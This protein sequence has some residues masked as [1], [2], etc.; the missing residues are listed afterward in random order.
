M[1]R[2]GKD[3]DMKRGCPLRE[4]PKYMMSLW[5]HFES[6]PKFST[7]SKINF[8]KFGMPLWFP[9]NTH[10][11]KGT[12]SKNRQS[13]KLTPTRVPTQKRHPQVAS[14]CI[15]LPRFFFSSDRPAA[16]S[17]AALERG[18]RSCSFCGAASP[19]RDGSRPVPLC[20]CP[21]WLIW[22]KHRRPWFTWWFNQLPGPSIFPDSSLRN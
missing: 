18:E 10:P 12:N 13:L 2:N 3:M 4:P 20:R 22:L 6:T 14:P 11:K 15:S 9:L 7:N 1:S 17:A 21:F 16:A 8:P 19:P 5:F